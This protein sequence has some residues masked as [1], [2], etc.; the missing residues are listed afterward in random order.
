MSPYEKLANAIIVS[1]VNDFRKDIKIVEIGRRNKD[2]A[3]KDMQE[4]LEFIRSDWFK[5]LTD[6]NPESVINKLKEEASDGS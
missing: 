4:I 6:L 5:V 3:I 2:A 1:A